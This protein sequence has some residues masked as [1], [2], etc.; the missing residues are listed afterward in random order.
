MRG[1]PHPLSLLLSWHFLNLSS[2][3][4]LN[5]SSPLTSHPLNLTL[6][7]LRLIWSTRPL[8]R[9]FQRWV[10]GAPPLNQPH[11]TFR[12][13]LRPPSHHRDSRQACAIYG[14]CAQVEQGNLGW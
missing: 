11:P 10:R 9:T 14:H 5:L 13:A 7:P 3:H 4:H 6:I 8:N 2:T 12:G 1:G